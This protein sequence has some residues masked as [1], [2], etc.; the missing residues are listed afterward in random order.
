MGGEGAICGAPFTYGATVRP[1]SRVMVSIRVG[2]QEAE[3]EKW[4]QKR[5]DMAFHRV[6]IREQV[7]LQTQMALAVN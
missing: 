1:S 6:V 3:R 5:M 7:S 2:F 4:G